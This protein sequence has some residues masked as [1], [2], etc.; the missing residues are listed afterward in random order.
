MTPD[1][2]P[3]EHLR[4]VKRNRDG[5][6]SAR[7]RVELITE[8][9]AT[10]M[11]LSV[12]LILIA[13]RYGPAGR[14]VV[15]ALVAGFVITIVLRALRFSRVKLCYRILFAERLHPRWMFWRKTILTDRAGE[16]FR[17]DQRLSRKAKIKPDQSLHV[18]YVEAAGR[19]ILLNMTPRDHPQAEHAEPSDSFAYAGGTLYAD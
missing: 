12:P 11:L 7:Q 3:S 15:L 16:P 17:F 19:R 1:Q 2:L 18:Y 9:L 14:T 10:L 8:P 6:L 4:D 13:G 5:R